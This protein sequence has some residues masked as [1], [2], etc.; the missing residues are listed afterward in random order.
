MGPPGR[1]LGRVPSLCIAKYRRNIFEVTETGLVFNAGEYEVDC[2]ISATGSV[3]LL[4]RTRH[5]VRLYGGNAVWKHLP[6]AYRKARRG[7]VLAG[8]Q[9]DL[10]LNPI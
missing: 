1:W 2:I 6:R 5:A 4:P 7:R 3:G 10:A 8:A 9:R